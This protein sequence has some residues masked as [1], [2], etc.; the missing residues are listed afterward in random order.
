MIRNDY[1]ISFARRI[2]YKTDKKS[3]EIAKAVPNNLFLVETDSPY[4][5]PEPHRGEIN[6]SSYISFIIK[7]IAE[8]KNMNYDEIEGITEQ[9]TRQ[10]FKKMKNSC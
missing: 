6:R 7:K 9:N 3:I 5:S 4:I 8:V 10:L 1:Y 2:T